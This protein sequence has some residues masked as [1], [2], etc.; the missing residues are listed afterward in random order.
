MEAERYVSERNQYLNMLK[1]LLEAFKLLDQH[2]Q[3][4]DRDDRI[5]LQPP[6]DF[7]SSVLQSSLD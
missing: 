6:R 7:V 3:H 5:G 1:D 4:M 2:W